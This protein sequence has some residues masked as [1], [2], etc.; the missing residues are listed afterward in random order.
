MSKNGSLRIL[1]VGIGALGGTIAARALSVGMNVWLATRTEESAAKLRSIGLQVSGIGGTASIS[2]LPHVAAIREYGLEPKFDL[3][4]LATKANEAIEVAPL[5]ARLLTPD[6]TLLPIQ[7]GSV[8]QILGERLGAVVLGGLSNLGATMIR[9]GSY[10]QRNAG[11]LLL[12]EVAGGWSNRAE[13]IAQALG[14][15]VET[16][17][18]SNFRNALWAKL[19]LNC[20]VTTIGAIA[21]QTMRQYTA[22]SVGKEVFR[23]SY[24]EALS[25]ALSRGIQPQ[26]M[27]VEPVPP[28]WHGTSVQGREYDAW[29]AS[30]ISAYGDLKASMLQ[31]FERGRR[32]EIDFINGYVAQAGSHLG[33]PVPVNTAITA[34]VRSIEQGKIQP[35]P[36]RLG[37]VLRNAAW[38]W[39]PFMFL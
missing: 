10:E 28:G 14:K 30:I 1:I 21:A 16:V 6:G 23:L 9:P 2:E 39:Q 8:S 4:V 36:E 32:T 26:Q 34:M 27:I 12:G 5:L 15:A 20:S 25:V 19:L 18:T 24:D 37:E 13:M 22:S 17:V 33:I 29:V 7:N 3:I 35:G 38:S 11:H 31:D